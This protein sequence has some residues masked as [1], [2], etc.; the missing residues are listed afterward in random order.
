MSHGFFFRNIHEN[1]EH[2]LVIKIF[3]PVYFTRTYISVRYKIYAN[4]LIS[5][6]SCNFEY[7]QSL[8]DL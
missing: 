2:S 7:F 5:Q 8:L 1:I 6:T 3:L 4:L